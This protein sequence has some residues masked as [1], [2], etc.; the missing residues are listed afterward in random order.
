MP[1]LSY[2]DSCQAL[3]SQQIIDPGGIPLF[4]QKP[5]RHDDEVLGVGFF[6]TMLA[7][8]KLEHL[9]LPRTFF[10]RSEIRATSFQDTDLSESTA[11]WNEF[12]D[13]DFSAAD[14]SRSDFRACVFERVFSSVF[15]LAERDLPV[16][17]FA[18]VVSRL[19]IFLAQTLPARSSPERP[20][21]HFSFH[22]T[23]S[24]L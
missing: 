18:T 9:T 16:L 24:K 11:N 10:G 1:R 2:E 22:L 5:P 7:D 12:I 20:A 13:V 17:I 15:G 8:S 3:Q 19:A 14:I 4:P 6:R 21:H 23:S